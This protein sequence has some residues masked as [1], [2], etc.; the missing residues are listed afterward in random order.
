MLTPAAASARAL[1]PIVE[2]RDL[3][4]SYR[5]RPILQKVAFKVESGL[6]AVTGHNGSGKSTLLR[7]LSTALTPPRETVFIG[8]AD[9][10][11][12]KARTEARRASGYLPQTTRTDSRLRARDW[13]DYGGWLQNLNSR[14]R[15][16]RIAEAAEAWN[17]HRLLG[18]RMNTLSVGQRRRVDLAR[19]SLRDDLS[20]MVLDEPF[21]ALD[22]DTV[23]TC[24][25]ILA[26]RAENCVVIFADPAVSWGQAEVAV[27]L[28][29]QGA[30]CGR[31]FG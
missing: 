4:F 9:L 7:L 23:R 5:R 19:T 28:A 27:D 18:R 17:L 25:K 30:L 29:V 20:V 24:Q 2:V 3:S 16:A 8:G 11:V 1:E 12:R 10:G 14:D 26:Q 6:Y 13:L 15:A 21:A 22:P 31:C